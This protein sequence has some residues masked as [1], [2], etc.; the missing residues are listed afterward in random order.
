MFPWCRFHSIHAKAV[1][2]GLSKPTTM[3]PP[4][5]LKSMTILTITM[6]MIPR[7]AG[8]RI[9]SRKIVDGDVNAR[10]RNRVLAAAATTTRNVLGEDSKSS[11]FAFGVLR[12]S[13][14]VYVVHLVLLCPLIVSNRHIDSLSNHNKTQWLDRFGLCSSNADLCHAR[15]RLLRKRPWMAL[16]LRNATCSPLPLE[17]S[18]SSYW[19]CSWCGRNLLGSCWLV[20]MLDCLLTLSTW[21]ARRRK[22]A[23]AEKDT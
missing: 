15:M 11:V 1:F 16:D 2:L 23:M 4:R 12:V 3:M 18:S 6:D 22:R 8:R 13:C 10:W 9:S 7:F 20:P 19:L 5:L 14:R 17:S 21:G